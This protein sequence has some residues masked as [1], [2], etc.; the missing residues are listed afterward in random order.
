MGAHR[1]GAREALAQALG[2]VAVHEEAD[3]AAMHAVDGQSQ[4]EIAVQ[5]LQHEAIAAE[6]DDDAGVLGRR[7]AVERRELGE[8]GLGGRRVAGDE[9]YGVGLGQGRGAQPPVT[10]I[11]RD[12]AGRLWRRSM[13]KSWPFGL[14]AVA[15]AIATSTASPPPPRP[16][17]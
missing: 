7:V 16:T 8:R 12:T 10:L 17:A 13:M 4:L 3:A 1:H 15:S 14:P 11:C 2:L 5:R 6:R 9:G